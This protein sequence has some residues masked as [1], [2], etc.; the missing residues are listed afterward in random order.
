MQNNGSAS[1]IYDRFNL[2]LQQYRT[3]HLSKF[4][5]TA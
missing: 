1:D 2:H 4:Y 5:V 3:Q